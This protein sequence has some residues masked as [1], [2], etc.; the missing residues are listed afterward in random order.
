M[1]LGALKTAIRVLDGPPKIYVRL[2]NYMMP[3]A[4]QKTPFLE[5][6]DAAFTE[7]RNQETGLWIRDDGFIMLEEDRP[8]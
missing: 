4:I 8:K 7:G 5:V 3:L 1:K 2:A 6:L